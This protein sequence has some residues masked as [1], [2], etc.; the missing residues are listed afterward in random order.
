MAT[1]NACAAGEV[2]RARSHDTISTMQDRGPK[3]T[4]NVKSRRDSKLSK[5]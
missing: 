3:V 1:Q 2:P 4:V 5:T